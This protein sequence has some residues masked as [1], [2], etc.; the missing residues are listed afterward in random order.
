MSGE[1][2]C[3]EAGRYGRKLTVVDPDH[4]VLPIVSVAAVGPTVRDLVFRHVKGVH[5]GVATLVPAS[6]S[7]SLAVGGIVTASTRATRI[8]KT[9]ADLTSGTDCSVSLTTGGDVKVRFVTADCVALNTSADI[10]RDVLDA[11]VGNDLEVGV[12]SL[13]QDAW[14]KV[15]EG[16]CSSASDEREESRGLEM[17]GGRFAG[18]VERWLG[19]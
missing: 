14:L 8:I 9:S 5:N 1:R 12:G 16:C 10:L 4:N 15:G 19:D 13:A 6:T 2:F 17:H 3:L 18:D 7:V 11:I